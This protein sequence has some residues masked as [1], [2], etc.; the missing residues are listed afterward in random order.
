MIMSSDD[1]EEGY[2]LRKTTE[3]FCRL[4][5]PEDVELITC[6]KCAKNVHRICQGIMVLN[7]TTR[8]DFKCSNCNDSNTPFNSDSLDLC[9]M[10]YIF[11]F[12]FS[13]YLN[14]YFII[15]NVLLELT[16]AMNPDHF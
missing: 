14:I 5:L 11:V 1:D 12:N 9:R 7:E 10:R 8:R 3:C 15:L 4:E 6:T 13:I 16:S 2:P